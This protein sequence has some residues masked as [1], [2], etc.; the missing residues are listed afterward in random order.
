MPHWLGCR[1][2]QLLDGVERGRLNDFTPTVTD[3]APPHKGRHIITG[4]RLVDQTDANSLLGYERCIIRRAPKVWRKL[5]Q[6]ILRDGQTDGWQKVTKECQ[7]FLTNKRGRNQ[8][9]EVTITKESDKTN[10]TN[11]AKRSK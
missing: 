8:R 9:I 1:S 10:K 5:P 3:L 6:D 11:E 7:R 4:L 2:S